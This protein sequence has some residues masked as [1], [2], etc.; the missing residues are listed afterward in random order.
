MIPL[1]IPQSRRALI[2]TGLLLLCA[3]KSFG[4]SDEKPW[5]NKYYPSDIVIEGG[6]SLVSSTLSGEGSNA[7]WGYG[8]GGGI[9]LSVDRTGHAR[10]DIRQ[11]I[12]TVGNRDLWRIPLFM[13]YRVFPSRLY[14]FL[15]PFVEL[16]LELSQDNNLRGD[17]NIH[18]GL[19]SGAGIEFRLNRFA[20]G[21]NVRYHLISDSYFSVNPY[22][23]YRM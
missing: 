21:I 18:V 13:G 3:V 2:L 11:Y 7:G 8:Y 10:L 5:W 17:T 19:S 6:Y 23:G 12:W 20:L 16:G 4:N 22:L 14:E 1:K 15:Q 9:G